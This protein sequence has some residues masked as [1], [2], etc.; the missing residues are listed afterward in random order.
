MNRT[1]QARILPFPARAGMNRRVRIRLTWG[2]GP[3]P[4]RAGMNR[5]SAARQLSRGPVTVPRTRGDEP[6][7]WDAAT[8]V[9]PPSTPFPA[10]AGMNR[11]SMMAIVHIADRSPH[12]RG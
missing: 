4:A 11:L 3:F 7:L 2:I 9:R 12:A 1:A 5:R 10:R 6:S 8:E